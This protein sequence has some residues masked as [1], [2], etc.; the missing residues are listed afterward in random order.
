MNILSSPLKKTSSFG[1][2]NISD[3]LPGG[4]ISSNQELNSR[5]ENRVRDIENKAIDA[6]DFI[7]DLPNRANEAVD[8]LTNKL[9]KRVKNL[10]NRAKGVATENLTQAKVT[11]SFGDASRWIMKGNNK[12]IV[13]GAVIGVLYLIFKK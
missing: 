7:T 8:N 12:F 2:V 13:L 5:L 3:S 4:R 11:S 10:E 6:V 1:I 9:I